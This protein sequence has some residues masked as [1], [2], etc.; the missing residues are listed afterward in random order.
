MNKTCPSAGCH[1]FWHIN[2]Q[3]KLGYTTLYILIN[4]TV[5]KTEMAAG[6]LW[7]LTIKEKN[8]YLG[9]SFLH[10]EANNEAHIYQHIFDFSLLPSDTDW[11]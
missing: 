10:T 3:V 4:T 7:I 6:R 8:E 2:F 5:R 11:R 9:C 1:K